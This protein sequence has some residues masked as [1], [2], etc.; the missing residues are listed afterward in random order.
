[1]PE[2]RKLRSVFTGDWH[3]DLRV[4]DLDRTPEVDRAVHAIVDFAIE[5]QVDFFSMGGDPTD[6]NTPSTETIAK[7]IKVLNRLEDAGILTF[8][9]KGNH[10]AIAAPGRLWGLRPLEEIGYQNV[11]FITEPRLFDFEGAHLLFLPHATRSQAV[12]E[13]FGSAQE[14]IDAKAESLLADVPD[15]VKATVIS[16]YNVDGARAGT[17]ALMLRQ[18]DLQLPGLVRRS[19]KVAQ[20]F[21]SH[22]HT[23]QTLGKI[24]MPGS[25]ICTDFGDVDRG[26]GFVYGAF[27]LDY[28]SWKTVRKK[29]PQAPMEEFSFDFLGIDVEECWAQIESA[30][31]HCHPEA[32][33]KIRVAIEEERAATFDFAQMREF[34]VTRNA[35]VKSF[36]RNIIRKRHRRAPDQDP[37]LPPAEAVKQYVKD[38]KPEGAERKLAL[39]LR[40]IEEG[41]ISEIPADAGSFENETA[42]SDLLDATLDQLEPFEL[43]ELSVD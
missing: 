16:H 2:K 28:Q 31:Q 36:D 33:V 15:H 4:E 6:N 20:I 13:G 19:P 1:M 22:I 37:N 40:F 43:E 3:Y 7:L 12:A 11:I 18:S 21:N 35:Y 5:K 30:S 25:P 14:Y 17:E 42:A 26:K 34:F 39:A 38:F 8:F 9:M 41:E 23:P 32:I 10:E 27:D 29:T 24:I